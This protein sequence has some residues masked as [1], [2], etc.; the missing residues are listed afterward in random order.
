MLYVSQILFF[1][2]AIGVFNSFIVALYLLINTSYS[3]L[4]NRLFGLFLLVLNLRVLKGLFYAFST[5]EPIWFLQSGPSF[6]LLIGPLLFS[7]VVSV[8]RPKSFWV[9]Y[10]VYHI[11]FWVFVV[12]LVTFFIS[13]QENNELTKTVIIPIIN[14]QGFIYILITGVF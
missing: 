9:R 14:L 3:N 4:S 2:G 10:W 12:F 6:F 11:L 1:F 5:K 13:F 8:V 7:Y